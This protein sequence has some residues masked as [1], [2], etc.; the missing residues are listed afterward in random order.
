VKELILFSLLFIIL[1][2]TSSA[3]GGNKQQKS[4]PYIGHYEIV[5]D[6]KIYP[7]IRDF[8]FKDQDSSLVSKTTFNN[9]I[10]IADFFFINCPTIC[11]KV[12]AQMKRVYDH[13][14]KEDR[15]MFLSHSIDTK[16]DTIPALKK[17]QT[18]LGVDGNKW[19]FVTGEKDS[20]YAIA[21]DYFSVAKEDKEAP[22]GFDHSGRLLLIDK[23]FH[24]RSFCDGTDPD[25][26]N[27]FI[28][29]IEILL[30]EQ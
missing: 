25:S 5:N 18:K 28:K 29:D 23:N 20:L 9:K 8:S 6:K 2:L 17:Y 16:Y 13:F 14:E 7:I 4:L 10:Y 12:K 15:L 24:V 26:V 21:A 27:D 22:G 1:L 11:P 3:C 30:D 19:K